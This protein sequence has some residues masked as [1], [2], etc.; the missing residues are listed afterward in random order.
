MQLQV[1]QQVP[2]SPGDVIIFAEAA[3]HGTLPWAADHERRVALYR[4]APHYFAYGRAYL[5]WPEDHFVDATE[6]QKAVLE[7]P[8]NMRLDRPVISEKT[9]EVREVSREQKK[10]DFDKKVYGTTYF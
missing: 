3:Q 10:K 8:Y 2:V 5:D 6:A 1:T 9:L 4:F 7:P